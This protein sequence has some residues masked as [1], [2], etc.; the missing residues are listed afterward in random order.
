MIKRSF[1]C[2][3]S[4]LYALCLS[5]WE[6]CSKNLAE[7]TAF[8][9]IYSEE[10][11]AERKNEVLETMSRFNRKQR[12]AEL[13]V[14][15]TDLGIALETCL[16]NWRSV[17]HYSEIAFEEEKLPAMYS[18]AGSIHYQLAR[19]KQW[20]EAL[21]MMKAGQ[22][23]IVK[24]KTELLANKNMPESFEETYARDLLVYKDLFD[25][26]MRMS[27]EAK[28]RTGLHLQTLNKLFGDLT[29]MFAA[30]REVFKKDKGL[31]DQFT[32]KN[33]LAALSG[34]GWAGI[35]GKVLDENGK[36]RFIEGLRISLEESGDEVEQ[37]EDGSF[38]FNRLPA[39]DY[40]LMVEAEGYQL[41]SETLSIKPDT[42][43]GVEVKLKKIIREEV[44]ADKV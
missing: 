41:W 2:T 23:F 39:G 44:E 29:R 34:T 3:E 32:V 13:N 11:V 33:S 4:E 27:I 36:Q 14:M 35:K 1:N 10:Y 28:N 22:A 43:S 12:A 17:K 42:Y 8:S 37:E 20:E 16:K 15:R 38:T 9:P 6:T 24:Y 19:T 7:L 31:A 18:E 40:K 21:K 5:G 30:A 26:F 25:K